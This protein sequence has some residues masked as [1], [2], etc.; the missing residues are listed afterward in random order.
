MSES[1]LSIVMVSYNQGPFIDE[2]IRSVISQ[3]YQDWSLIIVDDGSLDD[4]LKII[5][6]YVRKFP[7]K[8]RSLTHP[9]GVNLGIAA[10]YALGLRESDSEFIGFLEAD[11][12]WKQNNAEVKINLLKK[13]S[14]VGIVFSG[15]EYMGNH[16][17]IDLWER[18]RSP[19]LSPPIVGKA[20]NA[21]PY[22]LIANF[23]PSFSSV[24][25]RKGALK[26]ASIIGD[27]RYCVWLDWFVWLQISLEEKFCFID[28]KL[29]KWRKRENSYNM[30]IVWERNSLSRWFFDMR[31]RI[32]VLAKLMQE[33][34]IIGKIGLFFMWPISLIIALL[35]SLRRSAREILVYHRLPGE[36]AY[37]KRTL[38][39][40]CGD[41]FKT[42]RLSKRYDI[43]GIDIFPQQIDSDRKKHPGVDFRV[44][45]AEKLEFPDGCFD[46]IYALDVLEHV[47]NLYAA[48]KE[49]KRVL[50][51]GGIL[52]INIPYWRSEEW[53][54][55][56]RPTYFE[57]IHHVRT[58]GECELEELIAE[59]GFSLIK[60]KRA[61][62]FSHVF[63][64]YIFK[65]KTRSNSQL[66]IG[67]WRE[68]WKTK[69]VFA[70]VLLFDKK[71]LC[72][73]LKYFPVW[74]I[75]IPLGML[76]DAAGN[77]F[78]PKTLIYKFKNANG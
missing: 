26:N 46:E 61:E 28:K 77:I 25:M 2:A 40:G 39:I 15:F 43:T 35:L 10:S 13:L 45:N 67:N 56:L 37:N 7:R 47:D 73:P 36:K 63:Y 12:A 54:K 4:S 5:G 70:G 17:I 60:K 11:D 22:L 66:E 24:I 29:I 52:N 76:I 38:D 6:D 8:I 32:F 57:E 75:T 9:G 62:F 51:K 1:A 49:V 34:N 64:Y 23:I 55:K 50:K 42:A 18:Y 19:L 71:S 21:L 78:F 48:I 74:I 65:S 14:A 33:S 68:N 44:M 16:E 30:R 3:T 27:K 20:F 72:T 59:S 53:L 69:S 41:G 31:F 58:F